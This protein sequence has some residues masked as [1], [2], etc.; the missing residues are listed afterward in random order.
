MG[1][2][3]CLSACWDTLW[4]DPPW[5]D[6]PLGRHPPADG[7]CSGRY[8]SY[9]NAFLFKGKLIA[10]HQYCFKLKLQCKKRNQCQLSLW[11]WKYLY[12]FFPGGI[13]AEMIWCLEAK[14]TCQ[15]LVINNSTYALSWQA[16]LYIF[17]EKLDSG[18]K[19]IFIRIFF[20]FY[21]KKPASIVS[22]KSPLFQIC[23][24]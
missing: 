18:D 21:P 10:R 19:F 5:A 12:G 8:A 17:R 14:G 2:G 22:C 9:W 3:I 20:Y 1:R 15:F 4:A 6:P 11:E 7:Y 16:I 24:L 13:L 23:D